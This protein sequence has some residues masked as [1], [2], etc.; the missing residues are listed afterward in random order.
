MRVVDYVSP[1]RSAY[2]HIPFC[3]RRCFY[4]DFPI[5]PLG[6]RAS[7]KVGT[8]SSSIKAYLKL[9]HKEIALSP[10]GPP[11][12]TVYIGGGTPSLLS[13]LQISS[14]LTHLQQRF[15]LQQG[16]E[17]TLEM[18]PATFFEE[19][20]Y[21]FLEIGINR[22]SLGGQSFDDEQLEKMGRKH[23][24]KDV[25]EACSWLSS[26][27]KR[28]K[29]KSWSLDL[30]QNLPG[31]NLPDWNN[32]LY[33]AIST[34]VPHLSVYDLSIEEGTVFAWQKNR[35]Q[36]SVPSEELAAEIMNST[37]LIL[38]SS[39]LSRYEISSFSW[40]GHASRHNRVYW[41]G[42]GWWAF[43]L[44]ATSSP[45]GQRLTRPRT[46]ESYSHWIEKQEEEGLDDSLVPTKA[47]RMSL[48]EKILVGLRC[49]EGVDLDLLS[50]EWG[51]GKTESE[52][53][54]KMLEKR[55]QESIKMG[56]L[57][58]RCNRF[59]LTDPYGM[60][61]SNQVLVEMILWWE[62]LPHDAVEGPI[63]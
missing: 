62:S 18:D 24:R 56:F 23:R 22:I 1:P 28:G 33:E 63:L 25:L 52:T 5:V 29:L 61:V 59:T 49:R 43:G 30:I 19:D 15:G 53:Y 27:H 10:P 12:A 31:H 17:I 39:G 46:R 35:N 44:G 32:Q 55:W 42:A 9:L 58:K 38:S 60:T 36:L 2:L 51:W 45:W 8:G 37:S 54:I 20:L 7:G 40:P 16:A 50:S 21:K 57:E 13:P 26:A 41:R 47:I 6:D 4:C 3:Q 11:L 48:D 34:N 14:L